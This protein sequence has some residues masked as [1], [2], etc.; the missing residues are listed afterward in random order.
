MCGIAGIVAL[1]AAPAPEPRSAAA[2]GGRAQPPRPGRVRPLSRRRRRPRA[3][4]PVDHRPRHR[5]AADG[6]RAA[7]HV[8]RVQRRDLQ[9]PRAAR[10]AD[11]RSATASARA[12]TPRSSCRPGTPGAS[13]PSSAS[14]ASGRS[15][16]GTRW[17]GA[18]CWRATPSASARST[19]A[20]TAASCYFA[21]EVKAIFAAESVHPARLRS[22]RHRPDLH[23]LVGG[24]AAVGVRGRREAAARPPPHL[25]A[26]VLHRKTVLD[27]KLWR[28][29]RFPGRRG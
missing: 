1:G 2:H 17:R 4:A 21:S 24:P 23:V 22:C 20:S 5:P 28:L 19:F 11:A 13:A 9:L 6:R 15:R 18:W 10:R 29:H 25:S 16:S 14:T 12:A 7:H 8:D 3:R 27:A 26:R